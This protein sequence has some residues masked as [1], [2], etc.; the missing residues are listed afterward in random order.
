MQHIKSPY[1]SVLL[2]FGFVLFGVVVGGLAGYGF[3]AL[4]EAGALTGASWEM[5]E[6]PIR[7]T[8]IADAAT[9]KIWMITEEDKYYCLGFPYCDE[10]TETEK[11]T[12]NSHEESARTMISDKTCR[13]Y[14]VIKYP[15]NPKGNVIECARSTEMISIEA[16]LIVYYALLEDGTPWVWRSS[17]PW[18][19]G[20]GIFALF[21]F[22][23][24]G[25]VFGLIMFRSFQRYQKKKGFIYNL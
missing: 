11:V 15:R 2:M 7:F 3:V 20:F 14:G 21:A 16:Q 10:W 13:P 4:D 22:P 12:V 18:Y 8:H 19:V 1:L 5:I 6:S 9:Q 17:G 23:F 25:L 24:V